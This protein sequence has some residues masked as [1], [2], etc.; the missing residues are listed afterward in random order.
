MILYLPSNINFTLIN[1]KFTLNKYIVVHNNRHFIT[2]K[3]D[4]IK[5]CAVSKFITLNNNNDKAIKTLKNYIYSW[6]NFFLK[7]ITFKGKGYKITKKRGFLIL[8]FNHSHLTWL[9][10]FNTLCIKSTKTK[11]LMA[12]KNYNT[13]NVLMDKLVAIRKL[14]IYTK[15]GIKLSKQKIFR[16]VG[17]RT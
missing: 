3:I 6:A 17:K 4:G 1:N 14:N 10:L 15:R 11:Y 5:Y 2:L 9:L 16:K 12:L 13:L 7:K 8:N